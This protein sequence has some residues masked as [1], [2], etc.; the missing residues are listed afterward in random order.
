M[1]DE[2][3]EGHVLVVGLPKDVATDKVPALTKVSQ[4]RFRDHAKKNN[5][6]YNDAKTPLIIPSNGAFGVIPTESSFDAEQFSSQFSKV[7][8]D[9]KHTL[10]SAPLVKSVRLAKGSEE[11]EI[12]AELK[13][14]K[15]EVE[16][17]DRSDTRDW[18]KDE[19]QREMF[20]VRAGKDLTISYFE[21]A[22]NEPILVSDGETARDEKKKKMLGSEADPVWTHGEAVWSPLGSYLCTQHTPGYRLWAGPTFRPVMRLGHRNVTNILFSPD[23]QYA[24]SYN[25]SRDPTCPFALCVFLVCTGDLLKA[26]PP[27]A[28]GPNGDGSWPLVQWSHN[29]KYLA[30]TSGKRIVIYEMPEMKE[31]GLTDAVFADSQFAWQPNHKLDDPAVMAV[32]SPAHNSDSPC[33]LTVLQVPSLKALT[34]KNLFAE[35]GQGKIYW[36]PT[37]DYVALVSRVTRRLTGKKKVS[38]T[39]VEIIGMR[40]KSLPVDNICSAE[41]VVNFFWSPAKDR[42]AILTVNRQFRFYTLNQR[43]CELAAT[44]DM[45]P[46]INCLKWSPLGS[47]VVFASVSTA[48]GSGTLVFAQCVENEAQKT[49]NIDVIHKDEIGKLTDVSWDPSGRFILTSV[50]TPMGSA[51]SYRTAGVTCYVVWSFQGRALYREDRENMHAVSW[52]PHPPSMLTNAKREEIKL[53]MKDYS[54]K[55]DAIDNAKRMQRKAEL[56]SKRDA[57]AG[58][59]QGHVQAVDNWYKQHRLYTEWQEAI[60]AVEAVR[61]MEEI[62]VETE[63][64][65][66]VTTKPTGIG[67]RA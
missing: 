37:G 3:F 16:S 17:F 29:S 20:L 52:R 42:F 56:Q 67:A 44:K 66:S 21:N 31:I 10:R 53:H 13:S 63:E 46:E 18:I 62:V 41:D 45:G 50:T 65:I 26:M 38:Q 11:A 28:A 8:L 32:W 2:I 58:E 55:L 4:N 7:Q 23:E 14:I 49:Y 33:R 48:D 61:P 19:G 54:K 51:T 22:T 27:P 57:I 64:V 60:A 15:S 40:D 43:G 47:H 59:F 34:S 25:G 30:T 36:H 5:L 6:E 12:A 1:S 39:Q 24:V 9:K 35:N